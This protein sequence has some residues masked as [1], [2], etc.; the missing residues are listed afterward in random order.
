[1]VQRACAS[2]DGLRARRASARSALGACAALALGGLGVAACG[3]LGT[4]DLFLGEG[5]GSNGTGG[6]AT[7]STSS[8]S[9]STSSSSSS[10][11]SGNTSSSSSSSSSSSG[12]PPSCGDGKKDPIE[13][14]DGADLAGLTCASLGFSNPAGLACSAG[15]EL[16]PQGCQPTCDG[17]LR[18]PGEDCDGADL[19]GKD[20]TG[21]GFI[22]PQGLIC[23]SCQPDPS[24]CKATCGNGT[25]EPGETCDGSSL[26]GATCAMLG[27]AN[28]AGLACAAGCGGY[29]PAG[30]KP[31]C[32]N[33]LLEPTEA[34]DGNSLNG[35]T[36][37]DYGYLNP[38]GLACK[39]CA[40]DA[41][42]C[43]AVCG[44]GKV[45]PGEQCDD[46]NTSNNDGCSS[47][48]K[49][50]TVTAGTTCDSAIPVTVNLGTITRAGSTVGGGSH[51]GSCGSTAT[52]KIYLLTPSIS[53]FL[54]VSV[55]RPETPFD[56]V[57]Y[58]SQGC[59]DSGAVSDLLC[60]DSYDVATNQALPGGEVVSLKVQQ[61]QKYYVFVDGFGGNDAGDYQI[62]IDLSLGNC[63]DP[64]PIPLEPGA[65]MTLLGSNASLLSL[66]QGSC[67]GAPGGEVVYRITRPDAGDITVDTD[68][69][70]T[71]YN[72]VLYG[73]T[74]C[75]NGQTE[76]DCSNETGTTMESITLPDL[77][78]SQ[79][80]FVFVDGSQ[81]GGGNA[82]G[83]YGIIVTP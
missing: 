38:A 4:E 3:S 41:S 24:A 14:C 77:T 37:V 27:F 20:C 31:T 33:N 13:Q 36:C 39:S 46:G 72:S 52:D 51:A 69:A 62:T 80:V 70:T 44:N 57:L 45:E 78:A 40:L 23:K 68:A 83:N 21:F 82:S 74:S 7:T 50:E 75:S 54:T 1:M 43:Q 16:D 6:S 60:A 28:P 73:R 42:G 56:S 58:I 64:V 10:S 17:Q 9:G 35:K 12:T 32:N 48:C 47:T 11:S 29:D 15:C 5:G 76:I 55:S 81:S 8:S 18:E 61:G 19:G 30:C 65:P 22:Q 71:N 2:F 49:T 67:G 59:S 25:I 79:S 34:C 63:I 53:G 66:A 26:G